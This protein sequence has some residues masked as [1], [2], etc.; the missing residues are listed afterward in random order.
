MSQQSKTTLQSAINTQ[1]A[2]NTSGNITAANVRNNLINITDS[3][4]F[5]TGSGQAITGSLIVTGGITGSLQGTASWATNAI[6]VTTAATA[7]YINGTNTKTYSYFRSDYSYP[8]TA[9]F[10]KHILPVFPSTYCSI[11]LTISKYPDYTSAIPIV[12]QLYASKNNNYTINTG[13][14]DDRLIG[15]YSASLP[16][17][18]NTD[19][20][21]YRLKRSFYQVAFS[22]GESGYET[23]TFYFYGVNPTASI[24]SDESSSILKEL[25]LETG[26]DSAYIYPNLK[27]TGQSSAGGPNA[28]LFSLGPVRVTF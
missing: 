9:S 1:I 2:D 24:L 5:N 6:N 3:L 16:S 23:T 21:T 19:W 13:S 17:S 4:L 20:V 11:D 28:T 7:S 15:T 25:V 8:T 26:N 18:V 14:G 10:V 12:I 27:I 22:E